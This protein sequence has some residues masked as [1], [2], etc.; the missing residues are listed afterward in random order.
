MEKHAVI[1]KRV[2]W[3]TEVGPVLE[4]SRYGT[5]QA[6]SFSRSSPLHRAQ[7]QDPKHT[8]GPGLQTSQPGNP[9]LALGA[10]CKQVHSRWTA[11][12]EY[13]FFC[14]HDVSVKVFIYFKLKSPDTPRSSLPVSIRTALLHTANL[15]FS[16]I[17][18]PLHLQV[19]FTQR[20]F[21]TSLN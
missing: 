6:S 13:L 20:D 10:S 1:L 14:K 9:E 16:V 11:A 4:M 7:K 2:L 3:H 19:L 8:A 12:M 21:P 18:F 17:L 5:R 15:K